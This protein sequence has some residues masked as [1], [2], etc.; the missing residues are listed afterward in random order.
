MK[1][2]KFWVE[3]FKKLIDAWDTVSTDLGYTPFANK[4]TKNSPESSIKK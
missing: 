2:L 3:I 1:A 4:Q